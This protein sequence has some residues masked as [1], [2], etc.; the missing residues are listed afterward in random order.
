MRSFIRFI[1]SCALTALA[2]ACPPALAER[3]IYGVA[4][5]TD[6][7]FGYALPVAGDLV[8]ISGLPA[9]AGLSPSNIAMTADGTHLYV[10]HGVAA[11]INGF[12]IGPTGTV[13]PSA[14]SPYALNVNATAIVGSTIPTLVYVAEADGTVR[15]MSVGTL[16]DLTP[17]QG[18]SMSDGTPTAL[19]VAP[20]GDQL[21]SLNTDT[22]TISRFSLG[23]GVT[24]LGTAVPV[25]DSTSPGGIVVTPD[26]HSMYV[27]EMATDKVRRYAVGSDGG[28]TDE[29]TVDAGDGPAAMAVAPD[30]ST[31]LVANRNDAMISRFG[32]GSDGA[33][34]SL[35]SPT[36]G[37]VGLTS[38]AMRP[39][40]RQVLASGAAS[41][42]R[43]ALVSGTL[44]AVGL[45]TTVGAAFAATVVTPDQAPQARFLAAVAPAGGAS[46]FT[47]SPS[48]DSESTV[49]SWRW[50]FGD[51]TGAIGQ[52][53]THTYGAS[54]DYTVSLV[55]AD[56]EGC[57]LA[58]IA[59]GSAVLCNGSD[60]ARATKVVHVGDL[61]QVGPTPPP[62]IHIG[63]DGFCG[64]PD[65]KAPMVNVLVIRNGANYSIEGAP[66]QFVGTVS[67]DF[68]G[69]ASVRIRLVRP[70]KATTKPKTKR[71]KTTS[72]KA[73]QKKATSKKPK[74]KTKK[75]KKT[76]PAPLAQCQALVAPHLVFVKRACKTAPYIQLPKESPFI[77]DLPI[78]PVGT[79]QLNVL[80][81]DGAGNSDTLEVGRNQFTFKISAKGPD[82]TDTTATND[83]TADTGLARRR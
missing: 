83:Q 27:S 19:V 55:V 7:L 14:S 54:G 33:L 72:K 51:G 34:A 74:R 52:D 42:Q 76:K 25:G 62:C 39:D 53:V 6:Q 63:N 48:T 31:L 61:G 44:T 9:A 35:G 45:P 30:G 20:G 82:S 21:Y 56:D 73:K 24:K 59:I 78:L 4:P 28:L 46:S 32:V 65:Q 75:K 8:G 37:P 49:A 77:F 81:T 17:I 64:T 18:T 41:L 10:A 60:S 43:F 22:S 38:L 80:A 36:S 67:P 15:G 40:G 1:L 12:N 16:G 2:V 68:S 58:S 50:N 29:G 79:Y 11:T 69:L 71:K 26:G 66:S 57:S 70:I 3:A 5:G 47:G 23:A 13:V